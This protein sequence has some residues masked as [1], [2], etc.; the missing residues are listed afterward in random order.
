M[1]HKIIIGKMQQANP[2]SGYVGLYSGFQSN[3]DTSVVDQSG[4]SN[5]LVFGSGI[6]TLTTGE[7]WGTANA[8]STVYSGSASSAKCAFLPP[9]VVNQIDFSLGDGLLVLLSV[10]PA[11]P[12]ASTGFI[13]QGAS[14]TDTGPR[15]SITTG[16]VLKPS[17]YTE[18]EQL[19]FN[20][21]PALTP[22]VTNR[23]LLYWKGLESGRL[24]FAGSVNETF[25]Y[26]GISLRTATGA[27]G[28]TMRVSPLTV[29]GTKWAPSNYSAVSAA[30]S[31]MHIVKI[32][33]DRQLSFA[34]VQRIAARYKQSPLVPFSDSELIGQ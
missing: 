31:A 8:F 7:A 16:N 5:S 26:A 10:I 14:T 18:A 17:F 23:V 34:Q 4:N 22:G 9:S 2:S 21:P 12:A 13:S 32:P 11:T 6:S 3:T 24:G 19:V 15:C 27:C 30:F 33:A 29:G 1:N 20:D 25:A 28:N